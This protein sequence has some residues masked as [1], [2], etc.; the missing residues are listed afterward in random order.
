MGELVST[1][2]PPLRIARPPAQIRIADSPTS[3]IEKKTALTEQSV[4]CTALDS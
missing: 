3:S 4:F 2:I 1:M